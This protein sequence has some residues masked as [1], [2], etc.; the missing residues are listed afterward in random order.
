VHR[1]SGSD[2]WCRTLPTRPRR[3]K[4]GK[5]DKAHSKSRRIEL[6]LMIDAGGHSEN[7]TMK[8]APLCAAGVFRT[9]GFLE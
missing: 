7:Y 6:S 3:L 8:P 1:R 2:N 4:V 5:R 9:Y